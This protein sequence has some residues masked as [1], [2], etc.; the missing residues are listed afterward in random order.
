[1]IRK[2]SR[3]TVIVAVTLCLGSCAADDIAVGPHGLKPLPTPPAT[4]PE[5]IRSLSDPDYGVRLA[6]IYALRDMKSD[7]VPAVPALTV[8]LSDDVSDVRIASAEALGEIGPGAASAVPALIETLQLDES[9]SARAIAAEAL[10]KIGAVSAVPALASVLS[11]QEDGE[12]NTSVCIEA[13]QAIAYL[14]GEPFPDSEPGPHGYRLNEHGEPVL[15]IAA[16][17]W[18]ETSGRHETW[19]SVSDR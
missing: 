10:G 18:W 11:C 7:A 14:T 9:G 5:L 6:A 4:I 16:R 2:A 12:I 15:V 19:P 3:L 1:M 13:A 8:C 17:E